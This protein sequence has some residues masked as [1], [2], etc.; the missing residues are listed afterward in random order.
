MWSCEGRL[1][2]HQ[3]GLLPRLVK[4][5]S[6]K[7]RI[8]EVTAVL[9]ASW[10]L[11]HH[12]WWPFEPYPSPHLYDNHLC[13]WPVDMWV[14][15]GPPS[16]REHPLWSVEGA[17]S[18]DGPLYL[19]AGVLLQEETLLGLTI[20]NTGVKEP[21]FSL[22]SPEAPQR[23]SFL[24]AGWNKGHLQAS[25]PPTPG[26]WPNQPLLIPNQTFRGNPGLIITCFYLKFLM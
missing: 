4:Q 13:S 1:P 18:R 6:L 21:H 19:Q 8:R 25:L 10:N 22:H 7:W 17:L 24:M 15:P 9:H 20:P 26:W 23:S 11:V 14:D 16:W 2:T 5:R 12:Q 3:G